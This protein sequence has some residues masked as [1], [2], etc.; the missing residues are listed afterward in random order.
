VSQILQ[1]PQFSEEVPEWIRHALHTGTTDHVSNPRPRLGEIVKIRLELPAVGKPDQV[2]LRTIPNGEQQLANMRILKK[3]GTMNIWEGELLVNEP[4]V[5]YRFAIQTEGRI[6]W[7]NALGASR[8]MPVAPF[9]FLLLA[10]TEEIGWLANSVF[11]QIFPDRFA[12][13]DPTNDPNGEIEGSGGVLR[14]TYPWGVPGEASRKKIPF[15][16]GDLKGIEQHLD[17]LTH[18]GVNALYLNP[19]FSAYTNHRYDVVDFRQVDQTLGG[20]EALISLRQALDEL[21]MK[22]ILDIVPNHSGV[23]HPWFLEAKQEPTS[24]KRASYFFDEADNYVSWMGFGSLPKLNY[25]DPK[26]RSEMYEDEKSVFA[27]WLLPP[28]NIDGWRVDVGNMLGRL[29]EQQLD[30]EVLPAIRKTVKATNP[31]SYLMG[32]NFFQAT[33]QLQ[34]DAWDGV[35]NYSGFSDPLLNWLGGFQIHALGNKTVLDSEKPL[36]SDELVRSWQENL[37][38]IP[39]TIALQQFNL[40]DSHDTERLRTRLKGDED[41]IRLAVMVQFT[42]PGIP[43]I[44]YGDEIGLADEEGFAQRNCFPWDESRWDGD[45]LAFYQKLIGLRKNSEL[46]AQGSFQV[47]FWDEDLLIYQR[48]LHGKRIILSASKIDQKEGFV[49]KNDLVNPTQ[50]EKLK[51]LFSGEELEVE[52][53]E[54]RFPSLK[55]GGAIW[56]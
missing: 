19:I 49:L 24:P 45:L 11:Y 46:L 38:A 50:A 8:Y 40:L 29:D 53:G 44:Y 25:S 54:L 51:N 10:N 5:P 27:S 35:M 6:W 12:N 15:Y 17:Y 31:Q 30:G 21:D 48:Q 56:L 32:E 3:Q 41:L 4:R 13:G 2:V 23:G 9:D 52:I 16:G 14:K 18:L 39:W 37:A 34:G 42:F 55:R 26:L 20:N 47:L 43:C 7:L 28:F 22:L 1:T 33:G 36:G